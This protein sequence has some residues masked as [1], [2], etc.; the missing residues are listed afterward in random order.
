MLPMSWWTSVG[1]TASLKRARAFFESQ[2]ESDTVSSSG[3]GWANW[4]IKNA[5]FYLALAR[6]DTTEALQLAEQFRE[7]ACNWGCYYQRLTKAQLLAASGRD[8]EAVQL[9]DEGSNNVEFRRVP[10]EVIWQL[11]RARVQERLGN[12]EQAITDYSF[13]VDVWRN[14]D[15]RLQPLVNEAREALERLAGEG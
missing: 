14:A 12:I 2:I 9:L 13:V 6:R 1:D 15:E 7:Y 10:G 4:S 5:N 3:F 8:R 11:E